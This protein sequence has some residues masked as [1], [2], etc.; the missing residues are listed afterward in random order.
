MYHFIVNPASRSGRGKQIWK[1][2]LQPVLD[3][4]NIPYYVYYSEKAGDVTRLAR[5][6]TKKR[7]GTGNDI[8]RLV[9]LGGDGTLNEALQGISSYENLA[10]GYIQVG[11]GGDFAR[12]LK[13]P[14]DPRKA[15]EA[16]LSAA[17]SSSRIHAMDLGLVTVSQKEIAFGNSMGVGFDASVCEEI[18]HSR[19]K[20]VMNKLKLGKL[21][22]LAVALK[23]IMTAK[24]TSCEIY[25]DDNPKPI[26]VKKL[27]FAAAMNHSFEG[28]GFKFC[29]Q[30]KDDDGILDLCVA[31]N[32]PRLI[33]PFC[34][35]TAFFGLH[36][37]IPGINHYAARRIVIKS[38]APLWLH[39]DGEVHRKTDE[40]T[41]TC[42]HKRIPFIL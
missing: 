9:V 21:T 31:G 27:L 25:L 18:M 1:E 32:L 10:L 8:L 14:K 2:Y 20:T 16:I 17:E 26:R 30:A 28:G 7:P 3:K 39:T 19:L 4:K 29:P 13:L 42:C 36:F 40:V 22:Y 33:I 35:P 23:Q 37:I 34:L 5:Y 38:D 11:S 41:I 15:L 12:D 24:N 6:I